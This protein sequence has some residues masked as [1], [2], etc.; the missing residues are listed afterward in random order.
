[1]KRS[2][3]CGVLA[4]ALA[5]GV[6]SVPAG[7]HADSA[8]GDLTLRSPELTVTVGADF[9]RVIKYVD[10][11][12]GQ[13]LGGQPDAISTVTIDGGRRRTSVVHAGLRR[14]ARR[15]AGCEPERDGAGDDVRDRRGAR[16]RYESRAH[17]RHPRPRPG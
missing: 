14:S 1:M 6:L 12:S 9:P 13:A 8:D 2:V 10:N 4:V 15:R 11:A 16:D 7:A 5:A 3:G 17:H